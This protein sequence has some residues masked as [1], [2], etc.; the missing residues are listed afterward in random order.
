M[1]A[2]MKWLDN[3][4][5]IITTRLLDSPDLIYPRCS[6]TDSEYRGFVGDTLLRPNKSGDLELY[7]YFGL[8]AEIGEVRQ[9]LCKSLRP[10]YD[11]GKSSN[12]LLSELSDC[13]Y[14]HTAIGMLGYSPYPDPVYRK[15]VGILGADFLRDFNYCKLMGR[16]NTTGS[17]TK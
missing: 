17:F 9:V 6:V 13:H 2:F 10:G 11:Q 16:K 14:W 12:D 4:A 3:Q 5:E 15:G 7:L 8:Q 1:A